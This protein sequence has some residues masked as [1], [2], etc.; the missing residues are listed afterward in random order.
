MVSARSNACI[1]TYMPGVA[2]PSASISAYLVPRG[3]TISPTPS[4]RF[5]QRLSRIP[6]TRTRRGG[7]VD[8]I[9]NLCADSTVDSFR[10]YRRQIS[11]RTYPQHDVHHHRSAQ[12]PMTSIP[13][14]IRRSRP[15]P[16]ALALFDEVPPAMHDVRPVVASPIRPDYLRL[17]PY[18]RQPF[19]IAH[20]AFAAHPLRQSLP[21]WARRWRREWAACMS[22]SLAR[23][24][25]DRARD[26]K[27]VS[28]RRRVSLDPRPQSRTAPL[29][30]PPAACPRRPPLSRATARILLPISTFFFTYLPFPF[31]PSTS[32]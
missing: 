11:L 6:R 22:R 16:H 25:I 21:H 23:A 32:D 19:T 17:S 28:E 14:C 18:L 8:P 27:D 31:F 26:S 15:F 2:V 20:A 3:R 29:R 13:D 7:K 30:I 24:R 10:H 5:H 12:P 1:A 9:R 4:T